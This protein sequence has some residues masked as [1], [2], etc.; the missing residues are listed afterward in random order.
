MKL[1]QTLTASLLLPLAA[2]GAKQTG[3]EKFN[4]YHSKQLTKAGPLKLTDSSYSRL[5]GA[6][7]NYSSA[8]L[9]TALDARFGC[10]LC[11]EF[12]PEW[13]LLARSWIKGDKGAQSR[14]VFG[15]LDFLDGK[16]TF[17]SLGL[18]TAPILLVFPPTEG[19]HAKPDGQPKRLDFNQASNADTTHNFISSVTPGPHPRL[20]RPTDW[21]KI[22]TTTVAILGAIS[23]LTVAAPHILPIVQNRNLWAAISLIAILLFTSG[24][25]FNHIRKVPYVAGD[26]KGKVSYFAGGFQNQFGLETQIIAAIYGVLSFVTISLALKVPRMADA[27]TQKIAVF[28]YGGI[29][30]GTYSFLMSV[31]RIKNGGYPFYL[32]PF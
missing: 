17:Q 8:I 5:V 27:R 11:N 9:L 24:H 18:Q 2:L 13:D 25:M 16:G 4:D 30:F 1:L 23:F 3:D 6:P 26:G 15:T 12:Q 21:V 10:A 31:F 20:V 22:I 32:P 19:P 7:R 28:V 14:T 29:M